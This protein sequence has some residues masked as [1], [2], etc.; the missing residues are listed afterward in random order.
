STK[1]GTI[2]FYQL[3]FFK[4]LHSKKADG[5]FARELL[6]TNEFKSEFN[7]LLKKNLNNFN[8]LSFADEFSFELIGTGNNINNIQSLDEEEFTLNSSFLFG[9]IGRMKD[10]FN[11]QRRNKKTLETNNIEKE[12]DEFFECYTYFY[13]FFEEN[14]NKPVVTI[15]FLRSQAAPNIRC[16]KLISKLMSNPDYIIEIEPITT[17]DGLAVLMN[18]RIINSINY[19][20]ALPSDDELAKSIYGINDEDLFDAFCNL[21]SLNMTLSLRGPKGKNIINDKKS[22]KIIFDK[23][24]SFSKE[25]KC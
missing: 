5:T 15:A 25:K 16:L 7:N 3:Q 20:V 14:N 8:S 24:S 4:N 1:T 18:K 12:I 22:L 23:L 9:K 19:S 21:S 6:S 17:E 2:Y 13:M 11:F 10:I